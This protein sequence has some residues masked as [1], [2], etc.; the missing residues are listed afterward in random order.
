[1]FFVK[2]ELLVCSICVVCKLQN[3]VYVA[4]M[5][6]CMYKYACIVMDMVVYMYM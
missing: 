1:M 4:A 2:E 3:S 5:Y 6:I